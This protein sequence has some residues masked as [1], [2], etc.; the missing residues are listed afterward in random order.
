MHSFDPDDSRLTDVLLIGHE[1][2]ATARLLGAVYLT[3][4][5][6][7]HGDG[8]LAITVDSGRVWATVPGQEV[9]LTALAAWADSL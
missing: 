6:P 5:L 9:E 8:L 7:L 1:A 3:L 4:H 2:L